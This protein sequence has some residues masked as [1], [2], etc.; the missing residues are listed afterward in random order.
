RQT[1]EQAALSGELGERLQSAISIL[2]AEHRA[3]V[4]LRDVQELSNEQAAAALKISVTAFKTRLHRGRIA[5]RAAL[6]PYLKAT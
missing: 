1:P 3:A 4:V 2:P 6:E 5:V